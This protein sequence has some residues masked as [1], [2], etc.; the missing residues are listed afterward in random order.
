MF[1]GSFQC[2][3][4]PLS[5]GT[6]PVKGQNEAWSLVVDG[7]RKAKQRGHVGRKKT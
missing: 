3:F 1:S 4:L 2:N 7:E 5:M 6:Q